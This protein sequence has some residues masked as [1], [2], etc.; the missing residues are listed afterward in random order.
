M[1]LYPNAI[2]MTRINHSQYVAISKT[3]IDD[4]IKGTMARETNSRRVFAMEQAIKRHTPTGGVVSP[5][6]RLPWQV[7]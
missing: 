4:M 6:T 3:A 2:G 7:H 1:G 5:I